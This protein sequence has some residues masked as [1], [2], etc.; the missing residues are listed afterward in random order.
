EIIL[1]NRYGFLVNVTTIPNDQFLVQ[2][3]KAY[4]NRKQ[5]MPRDLYDIVWLISHK[6]KLDF[7]FMTKNKIHKNFIDDAL[8]KYQ[9]EK[10][11][12]KDY[13]R[14]LEPFLFNHDNAKKIEFFAQMLEALK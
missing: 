4:L 12:I 7:E 3:L 2:K 5:T 8:E 1:L 11:K 6:A 14:K 9:M 10:S 13:Q